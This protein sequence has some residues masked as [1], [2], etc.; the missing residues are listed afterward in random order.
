MQV[1]ERDMMG[2]LAKGLKVVEAFTAENPRLSISQAAEIAGY[3]RATTRRCLLTLAELG[4]CAYDGKFFTVTPRVLRLGTGCLAS[5][6]LP[7]IIQPLLDSLSE[8]IGESTS[9]SILDAWEIVYIARASQRKVMSITL[10][11]GSRLPAYCTSM[12]RILLAAMSTHE[13]RKTL[14]MTELVAR[15]PRTVTDTDALISE[16]HAVREAGYAAIDQEVEVGLRSLAV[17]V[18]NARQQVVAAVNVG[19]PAGPEPMSAVLDKYLPPLRQFQ[20]E[21]MHI[22]L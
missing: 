6:P 17:P 2:G 14:E 19:L 3:D 9:V 22:I 4:Y 20:A 13:A 21:I 7:R 1:K 5:M 16:L 18:F 12:G 8:T 10:M 11:P 15:T